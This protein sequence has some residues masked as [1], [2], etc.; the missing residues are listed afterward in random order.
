MLTTVDILTTLD[1]A[2]AMLTV[3]QSETFQAWITKL[4]DRKGRQIVI[5]RI[6][7][8]AAGNFGDCKSLGDGVCELRIQFGP[9]YRVYYVRDGKT[10]MVLLCG[11]DKSTQDRD[12]ER[13]KTMAQDRSW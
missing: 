10:I 5:D 13:A 7:R 2:L 4:K 12:I 1:Y 6:K 9:G 11:G 3:R 8:M